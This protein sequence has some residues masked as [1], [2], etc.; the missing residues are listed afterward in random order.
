[1]QSTEGA[2]E[3]GRGDGGVGRGRDPVKP[4][5]VGIPARPWHLVDDLSPVQVAAMQTM[6]DAKRE[7]IL[8]E[9][10]ARQIEQLIR[11]GYVH[12]ARKRVTSARKRARP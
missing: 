2:A 12:G 1:M 7:G 10:E 6:D 3:S 11:G 9:E 8:S 5:V 4:P